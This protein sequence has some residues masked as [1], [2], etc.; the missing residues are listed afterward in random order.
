M[1]LSSPLHHRLFGVL[2]ASLL[3]FLG[4]TTGAIPSSLT[5]NGIPGCAPQ[6]LPPALIEP[7][8]LPAGKY[9]TRNFFAGEMTLSFAKG[10][11]SG[12]DS[13]GEFWASPKSNQKARVVFWEDVYAAKPSIPG[14]WR[15]VG[16]LRPTSASLLAWLQKNPNLTVSKPRSGK[17]GTIHARVV[18][19]GVSDAAVND[20]PGCPAK[21]CANFLLFPQWGEPYGIAGKSISRFY[22]SDV[23]YGGTRH[24]FVAVIEVIGRAELNAFLPSARKLIASVR[25]P[26][27]S[28]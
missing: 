10:W 8:N 23:R 16:P 27:S 14:Y 25:V 12:E 7:G 24:L 18:D 22:F 19:I 3:V 11:L 2:T 15:R 5:A 21:A 28:A 17:I 1:S 20:D 26:A 9:Q 4:V 6:C 13:T